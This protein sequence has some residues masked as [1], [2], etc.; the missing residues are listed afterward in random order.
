MNKIGGQ[1]IESFYSL[2]ISKKLETQE[3]CQNLMG[4]IHKFSPKTNMKQ[5]Q[6]RRL[7]TQDTRYS[8]IQK[9][10]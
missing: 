8:Y 4:H 7:C 10:K 5:I 3:A 6:V 9:E 2:W 1:K